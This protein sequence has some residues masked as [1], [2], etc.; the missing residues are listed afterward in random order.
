MKLFIFTII[1]LFSIFSTT[2]NTF[3]SWLLDD[4]L[5]ISYWYET[6]KLDNIKLDYYNFSDYK[7]KYNYNKIKEV[8]K[9][10]KDRILKAYKDSRY[11]KTKI[12]AIID[13]YETFI[14][15]TNNLFYSLYLKE[16]YYYL[17]NDNEIKDNIIESYRNMQIYYRYVNLYLKKVN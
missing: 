3:A 6:S 17:K 8:N 1:A 13:N 5:D 7:T 15:Y 16:R 12:N 10:I 2:N 4:I 9:L 11:T 14:Y